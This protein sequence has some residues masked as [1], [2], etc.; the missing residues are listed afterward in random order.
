[1]PY[2]ADYR[3]LTR[4]RIIRSARRLFNRDGFEAVSIDD[5]MADAAQYLL[6]VQ[7]VGDCFGV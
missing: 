6:L 2:P 4:D 3:H 1:M 5:V 7:N